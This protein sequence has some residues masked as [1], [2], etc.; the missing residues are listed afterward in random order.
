MLMVLI[1]F[2]SNGKSINPAIGF[3]RLLIVNDDTTGL[4]NRLMIDTFNLAVIPPSSGVQFFKDRIVF[5]SMS[6]YEK[7]MAPNQ[8]SFG[9][10]EAYTASVL[11]SV[12]GRHSIFSPLSSFSYPCDAMTF[13][14]K[15]D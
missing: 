9:A 6:K 11:D 14:P 13:T 3:E 10:I 12:T 7:K 8:I 15:Y 2:S 5:L 4:I 1:P